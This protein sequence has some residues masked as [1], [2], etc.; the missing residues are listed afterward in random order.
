MDLS[1]ISILCNL[2]FH[3]KINRRKSCKTRKVAEAYLQLRKK[4]K[5][6]KDKDSLPIVERCGILLLEEKDEY[7]KEGIRN[8]HVLR[9]N[10][11]DWSMPNIIDLFNLYSLHWCQ[12][13]MHNETKNDFDI[14]C[15]PKNFKPKRVA[16]KELNNKREKTQKQIEKNKLTIDEKKKEI[17]VIDFK[18]EKCDMVIEDK[19]IESVIKEILFNAKMEYEI[20]KENL[21]NDVK[22]LEDKNS[23]LRKKLEKIEDNP[24]YYELRE[25]SAEYYILMKYMASFI[26]NFITRKFTGDNSKLEIKRSADMIY[27]RQGNIWIDSTFFNVEFLGLRTR[28]QRKNFGR[29]CEFLN[30][31]MIDFS[32]KI[33]RFQIGPSTQKQEK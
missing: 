28:E 14:D 1:I 32:G 4:K 10:I 5:N 27:K 31:K 15:C 9:T 24:T 17:G 11:P 3:K 26:N 29:I 22:G 19:K 7:L 21:K 20:K 18:I 23:F 8:K 25:E 16:N 30:S 12:E 33:L 13:Q 2:I 6:K